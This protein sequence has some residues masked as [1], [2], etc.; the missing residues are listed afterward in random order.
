MRM[1]IDIAGLSHGDLPIPVASRVGEL[2]AT[3]GIRGVDRVS[4]QMPADVA[5]QTRLMFENLRSVVEAAGASCDSILKLTIWIAQPEARAAINVEWLRLF[6]DAHS[7]PARHI[8]NYALPGGMLVQCEALARA[9]RPAT[10]VSEDAAVQRLSEL[11]ACA[12]SDALDKI[13]HAGVALGLSALSAPKRIFGRAVTVKLGPDDGRASKRH[14]GTA[15]VEACNA[16]SIIVIQHNGR[17]DVSGWGGI[18]SL[19]AT[20]KGVA[21][22][23]IDGACRDLDESREFG[24]PVYGRAGVPI[25]ARGRIIE[26]DWNVPVEICGVKVA[27]GDLVMADGSG[28]VVI[29]QEQADAVLDMAETI[30]EKERLM[31]ASVRRGDPVSQVMGADYESML[32]RKSS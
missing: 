3:G 16:D 5:G 1:S 24:L 27:P 21:G 30:V 20:R 23:V 6:P 15:A 4:G 26:L 32:T 25:T 9:V 29:P 19:A 28:I 31:A 18:L 12:V 17:T 14:L 11:D 13:G 22:V 10:R 7:R 8:L 2:V